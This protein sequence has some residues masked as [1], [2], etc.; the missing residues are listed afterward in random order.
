MSH[1]T[2]AV[3][4]KPEQS[5][6]ELLAPYSEHIEVEPYVYETKTE[7]IQEM[8]NLA[9][10]IRYRI[11]HGTIEEKTS[12]YHDVVLEAFTDEEFYQACI[13][14][15]RIDKERID[16]NGNWLTTYNPES[17]WD[18]WVIGGRFSGMLKVPRDRLPE[19]IVNYLED[20]DVYWITDEAPIRLVDFSPNNE[21]Y[22]AY[23][24]WWKDYVDNDDAPWEDLYNK[25]YYKNYYANAEDYAKRS[26]RFNTFAVI[27]P[28]GK[29]HERGEMGWFACSSDTP[30]ESKNWDD[31]YYKFIEN[32]EPNDIM[33]IVDCHI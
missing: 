2:V 26:S 3:I 1:F 25:N 32:A 8:K 21:V 7:M 17:K 18:W 19:D 33:T 20:D 16:E 15:H 28:D 27:T 24:K 29:W 22:D 11:K 10:D 23:Y 6:E 12:S 5:I 13:E 14:W 9:D 30:E 31:N 4:H